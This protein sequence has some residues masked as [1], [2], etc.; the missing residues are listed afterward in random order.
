MVF[1]GVA[2]LVVNGSNLGQPIT[3]TTSAV[4]RNETQF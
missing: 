3:L 2:Q 1:N 4:M